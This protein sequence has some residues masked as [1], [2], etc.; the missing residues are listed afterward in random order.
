MKT[1][2]LL[3]AIL[4]GLTGL[5]CY[6]MGWYARK[7]KEKHKRQR[8]RVIKK[9]AQ[10]L[11]TYTAVIIVYT[12]SGWFKTETEAYR[13]DSIWKALKYYETEYPEPEYKVVQVTEYKGGVL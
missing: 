1:E 6:Q 9:A 5:I 4:G 7:L 13:A 10:Q 8:F 11:K 2:L 12:K 3:N